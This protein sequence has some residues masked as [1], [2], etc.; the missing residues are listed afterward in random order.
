[1]IGITG[2]PLAIHKDMIRNSP[3]KIDTCLSYCHYSMNDT[4]LLTD[5]LPF[6]EANGIALINASAI[7]MGLLSSRGPPKWHPA[8]S[9]IKKV[10]ADACAYCAE[11]GVDLSKLALH[12]SLAEPSIPTTLVSTASATRI[13]GNIQAVY[14]LGNLSELENTTMEEVLAK[15]FRPLNNATWLDIEPN[16]FAE[17]L[18]KARQGEE[19]GTLSTN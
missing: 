4:S 3:V 2:F 5:L 18:V 16:E 7:S 6:L 11:R 12:F 8:G 17:M 1:M 10:C 15:F 19:V 13:E 14:D 9:E